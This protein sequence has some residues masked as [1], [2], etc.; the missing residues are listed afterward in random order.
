VD[1]TAGEVGECQTG[2][3]GEVSSHGPHFGEEGPL[4]GGRGSGTIFFTH[5]NLAC[6]FCQNYDISQLGRGEKVSPEGLARMMLDLQNMG[7]LNINFVSPTHVV[8]QILS[9]LPPAV[10][11][12]LRVPLVYN[13]GGYDSVG[14]LEFLDGVVD[15]YMPD[16]KYSREDAGMKYSGVK[17]YWTVN[18]AATKEMFRQV[19]DLELDSMGAATRG[20]LVRHLVLPDDRAGSRGILRFIARDLSADTY[21]NI[22][23]QYRPCHHAAGF[24]EIARR[25]AYEEIERVFLWAA[26]EGLRR[27]DD[28]P[29]MGR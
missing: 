17:D 9:A 21:V 7:C 6:Q 3:E 16:M 13:T 27:L 28:R 5:C 2:A 14:T 24:P 15:I 10:E 4:V 25:P 20:L 18:Q 23:D 11:G 1:R 22:M 29:R 8:A 26:E 19:G 12:G